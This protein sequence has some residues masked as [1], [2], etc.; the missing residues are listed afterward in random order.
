V[1]EPARNYYR[2]ADE[3]AGPIGRYFV[4]ESTSEVG[5]RWG[6]ARDFWIAVRPDLRR[7]ARPIGAVEAQFG[8]APPRMQQALLAAVAAT[9][10][11]KPPPAS[12]RAIVSPMVAWIWIGGGVVLLGALTALW[13]AGD[14]RLAA[15]RGAYGARLAR[16]LAPTR[17]S[18]RS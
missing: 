14:L 11:D 6:L 17:A 7:L 12:F 18:S 15:V 10:A 4:G 5:V 3:S 9:Y 2:S 1:L 16:D 13:P 8:G